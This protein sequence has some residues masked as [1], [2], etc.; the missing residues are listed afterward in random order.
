[1]AVG[2]NESLGPIQPQGGRD[3]AGPADQEVGDPWEPSQTLWIAV[4]PKDQ[5]GTICKLPLAYLYIEC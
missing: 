1:M 4:W 3:D 5:R 2:R